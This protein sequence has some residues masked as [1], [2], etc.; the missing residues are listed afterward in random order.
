MIRSFLRAAE[1]AKGPRLEA[2]YTEIITG[3]TYLAQDLHKAGEK[4]DCSIVQVLQESSAR[5]NFIGQSL[6][7]GLYKSGM[8]V[9]GDAAHSDKLAEAAKLRQKDFEGRLKAF[10][11]L[12]GDVTDNVIRARIPHFV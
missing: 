2:L 4:R 3:M 9:G 10:E 1:Q 6:L 12:E 8:C 11:G 7:S 5:G